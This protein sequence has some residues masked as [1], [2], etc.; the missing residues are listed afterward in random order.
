MR[1]GFLTPTSVQALGPVTR[2]L[3]SKNCAVFVSIPMNPIQGKARQVFLHFGKKFLQRRANLR[4]VS[5]FG[6]AVDEEES[7]PLQVDSP[8]SPKRSVLPK[9]G[10]FDL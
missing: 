6:G 9:G 3:F 1:G 2:S 7:T 4:R 10:F 5:D 8:V